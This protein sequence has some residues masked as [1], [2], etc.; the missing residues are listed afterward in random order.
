MKS[1]IYN[2]KIEEKF[3]NNKNELENVAIKKAHEN[4][5]KYRQGKQDFIARMA[6]DWPNWSCA[7]DFYTSFIHPL[8]RNSLVLNFI[9]FSDH[10]TLSNFIIEFYYSTKENSEIVLKKFEEQFKCEDSNVDLDLIDYALISIPEIEKYLIDNKRLEQKNKEVKLVSVR[11]ADI[12]AHAFFS[13]FEGII[14]NSSKHRE[15]S[16]N[17]KKLIV[18]VIFWENLDDFFKYCNIN[19]KEKVSNS[20]LYSCVSISVNE[21]FYLNKCRKARTVPIYEKGIKKDVDLVE[22][23]NRKMNEEIIDRTTGILNPG[24]WGLKEI[25]ACACFLSGEKLREVNTRKVTNY[26][27]IDKTKNI[28]KDNKD[29]E[30]EERIIYTIK[31]EKPHFI[32]TILPSEKLPASDEVINSWQGYGIKLID[33]DQLRSGETN[34]NYDFL[35]NLDDDKAIKDINGI[36]QEGKIKIPQRRI[37][38]LKNEVDFN[39]PDENNAFEFIN[40]VYEAWL[41]QINAFNCKTKLLIYFDNEKKAESWREKYNTTNFL[42]PKDGKALEEVRKSLNDTDNLYIISRHK[43]IENMIN[44]LISKSDKQIR[45]KDFDYFEEVSYSNLFFSFLWSLNPNDHISKIILWKIIE[46]CYFKILVIDERIAQALENNVEKLKNLKHMRIDIAKSVKTKKC[47]K[48]ILLVNTKNSNMVDADFSDDKITEYNIIL[49]HVTRLN[50]IYSESSTDYKSKEEFINQ[51]V[52]KWNNKFISFI[53]HSGR[54]KTEGDIPANTPFLEYS[55]VQK[56]LIQEPS[57]F[58]LTQIAISVL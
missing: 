40:A 9:N 11:D 50:E 6:T 31:L 37:K 5:S 58:Y 56:Y 22:F 53:V 13:L 12:G 48:E 46:S 51:F 41:K 23:L 52:K 16:R 10:I 17:F 28:W 29:N 33:I 14:R 38:D 34:T 27:I 57:K 54:G 20:N 36:K 43:T 45:T 25:K 30:D 47:S 49:I 2:K 44:I 32:L 7:L 26:L 21:D 42:F 4:L 15:K 3:N 39:N 8:F 18:K 19:E 24:S 55:I 1:K 35:V